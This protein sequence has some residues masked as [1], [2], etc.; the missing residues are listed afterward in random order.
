MGSLS[1][2]HVEHYAEHGYVIAPG[3]LGE[4]QIDRYKRRAREIA[5]GALIQET[6]Q[7][8]KVPKGESRR[9]G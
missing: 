9:P 4:E 1:S 3:V 2:Q 7:G 6:L 5:L 8:V